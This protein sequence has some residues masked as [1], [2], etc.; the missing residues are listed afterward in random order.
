MNRASDAQ[1]LNAIANHPVIRP[2]L[3]GEGVIDLGPTIADRRNHALTFNGGG[4]I[5][6]ALGNGSYEVHSLALPNP[7]EG[8]IAAA[9]ESLDHMFTRTDCVEVWTKV[10]EP[11]RGALGLVRA[12]GFDKLYTRAGA[13]IDGSAITFWKLDL[14][15]WAMRSR[16]AQI[17][18]EAFHDLL[19]AT[20]GHEN[21]P[22]DEAHDHAAGAAVLM[23]TQDQVAKAAH[24]YNKWCAVSGYHTINLLSSDPPVMD[25]GTHVLGL[26][27]GA[28]E[29]LECR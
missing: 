19:E 23:F 10:P 9:R 8:T 26:R 1:L 4:F 5:Y 16:G 2:S 27:D 3:G 15:R 11:N 25:I 20:Q 28:L 29:V 12:C 13:W 6:I 7:P 21:H 17:A 14:D 22:D 24:Y 18:G